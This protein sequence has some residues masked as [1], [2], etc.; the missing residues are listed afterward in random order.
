VKQFSDELALSKLIMAV[1]ASEL[2][3][4]GCAA[5]IFMEEHN[6]WFGVYM[7]LP[8]VFKLLSL[9]TRVRREPRRAEDP[10]GTPGEKADEDPEHTVIFEISDYDH[11]FPL[12]EGPEPLVRQFFKHWG[13]P[14]R[15][16]SRDRFREVLG[17]T[18]VFV[19]VLY[20]PAGLMSLLWAQL[21][22]QI[23]WLSYQLYAII[24]MHITR[25]RG[26]N[27]RGRMEEGLAAELA[28]G[29]RVA[30]SSKHGGIVMARL[31][32]TPVER[33]R[34]GQSKVKEIVEKHELERKL[35]R[36]DTDDS[37]IT[38]LA[39]IEQSE[40]VAKSPSGLNTKT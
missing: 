38:L 21:P 26:S 17:I 23:I 29:R 2:T 34:I 9:V 33:I 18:L 4:V 1:V 35:K 5:L 20:F 30:L 36:S 22:V 19:F 28:N 15:E 24:V 7:C 3:A 37:Q 6:P 27:G 14:I 16:N 31:E 13:H 11:G 32:S 8:L 10:F 25:L 40:L 39:A 12:I